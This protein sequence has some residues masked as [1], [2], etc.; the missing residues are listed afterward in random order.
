[1]AFLTPAIGTIFWMLIIF[2]ITFWILKKYAWKPILHA[3]KQR[4]YSIDKALAAADNARKEIDLL[5]A[6]Q[7]E[8]IKQAQIEKD[9]ILKEAR[10]MKDQMLLEAKGQAQVEAQ[11][12]IHLAQEEI[13]NQQKAAVIE[14]KQEIAELSVLVA[15]KVIAQELASTPKQEALVSGLI[16]NLKLN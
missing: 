8:I 3:L 16:D 6:N 10:E 11:K 4:E 7:E 14:M 5:R 2:G 9:Q 1:M 13:A 15:S 12:L